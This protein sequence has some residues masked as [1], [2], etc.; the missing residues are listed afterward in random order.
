MSKIIDDLEEK[1]RRVKSN[2][3]LNMERAFR[4]VLDFW[5]SP[6]TDMPSPDL[7]DDIVRLVPDWKCPWVDDDGVL[8]VYTPW[9]ETKLKDMARSD[10]RKMIRVGER[11]LDLS[12]YSKKNIEPLTKVLKSVEKELNK[13]DVKVDHAVH[14]WEEEH[15][16]S[17][18][19][20]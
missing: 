4:Y 18:M 16:R 3:E 2:R 14:R 11:L 19:G 5:A 6:T 8:S 10:L 20:N 12:G 1:L 9:K 7:F 17:F 13:R 15:G